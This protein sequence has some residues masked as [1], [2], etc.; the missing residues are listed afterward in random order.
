MHN[1]AQNSPGFANACSIVEGLFFK[2]ANSPDNK[3]D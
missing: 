1:F 3:K 2:S